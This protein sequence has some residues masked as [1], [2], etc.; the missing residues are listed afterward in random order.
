M[1]EI[2]IAVILLL[3]LGPILV[4]AVLGP[5]FVNTIGPLIVWRTQTLPAKVHFEPLEEGELLQQ[6][7]DAFLAYDRD[8]KANGFE[9]LAAS[10]LSDSHTDSYFRLYW[11]TALQLA[12]TGVVIKGRAPRGEG[13]GVTYGELTQRYDDGTVLNV[14]N[15]SQPEAFPELGF[16]KAFRFPEVQSVAELVAIHGKLRSKYQPSA[17]P[18]ILDAKYCLQE[19]ADYI[20]RESEAL[21]R[22]GLCRAP[23]D[24][25]GRRALTLWGAFVLTSRS[26]FPGQNWV[27]RANRNRARRALE[28]P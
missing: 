10:T 28:N 24:A 12:A 22:L 18:L 1:V 3:L 19:L 25:D 14:S 8:F 16:K 23:I 26:V 9:P 2:V 27:E 4:K 15:S 13:Q 17:S 21:R 6:V 20:Y 11:H 7:D 5:V